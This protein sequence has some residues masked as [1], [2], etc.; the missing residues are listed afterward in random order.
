MVLDIESS[1]C[2]MA[3]SCFLKLAFSKAQP[4]QKKNPGVTWA[5]SFALESSGIIPGILHS[6]SSLRLEVPT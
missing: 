3:Q 6:T 5:A 1:A 4:F 2:Q